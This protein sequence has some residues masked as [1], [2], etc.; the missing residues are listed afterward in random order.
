M[1]DN[2]IDNL[3][4]LVLIIL[5]YKNYNLTIKCVHKIL[6]TNPHIKIIVID[7]YSQNNAYQKLFAEF[8]F[9]KNINVIQSPE[10]GGYA[11]GNNIGIKYAIKKYKDIK[12]FGVMNPDVEI[13][14]NKTLELLVGILESYTQLS[15]VTAIQRYNDNYC[16]LIKSAWKL[17]KS[18]WDCMVF[19]SNLDYQILKKHQYRNK[20]IIENK[21]LIRVDVISGCFFVIRRKD[22]EDV[23]F[24]DETTFL[25]FEENILAEKLKKLNKDFAVLSTCEIYH[26]HK[27]KKYR[28]FTERMK[29][30]NIALESKMY[31]IKMYKKLN[32]F[33]LAIIKKFSK[34]DALIGNIII[35]FI[36]FISRKGK[37][38]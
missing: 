19:N 5:N 14:T 32:C 27:K 38:I 18:F 23:N 26:N 1:K 13:A 3:E 31:Y 36:F 6:D 35:V 12:Y 4:R 21:K 17:P 37:E 2:I 15:A 11:K 9:Y 22:F 20:Q 28:C 7:N 29:E 8:A 33:E 25:Y 34:L 10:N 30:S 16:G 24:F